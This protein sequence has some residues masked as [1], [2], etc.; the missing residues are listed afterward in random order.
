MNT[1]GI[2]LL[3]LKFIIENTYASYQYTLPGD[4]N[5]PTASNFTSF[6]ENISG[7]V[8]LRGELNYMPHTWN[9]L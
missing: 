1:F 6:R 7:K 8:M 3:F 5:W 9:R 2:S 4:P